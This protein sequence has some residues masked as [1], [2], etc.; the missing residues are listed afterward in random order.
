MYLCTYFPLFT[1]YYLTGQG[2]R[3]KLELEHLAWRP[4]S[5][6]SMERRPAGVGRPERPALPAGVLIVNPAV[7]RFRVEAHRIRDAHHHI[8]S[9]HEHQQRIR[10][11]S[12]G[13]RDVGPQTEDVVLID[14]RVIAR[15]GTAGI[16]GAPEVRPRIRIESPALRAVLS[17]C[18]RT[19]Q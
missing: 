19:V 5:S 18:L 14:P 4:P 9:V 17:R 6:F 2:V 7:H 3:P 1:A 12:G 11:A 10:P 13:D 16:G 8:A 15:V